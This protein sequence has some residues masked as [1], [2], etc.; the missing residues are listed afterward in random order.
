MLPTSSGFA[1]ADQIALSPSRAGFPVVYVVA[2]AQP[3][4]GWSR[5]LPRR[6]RSAQAAPRSQ[7]GPI[8]VASRFPS[9][10]HHAIA[11]EKFRRAARRDSTARDRP[12]SA[13]A[14]PSDLTYPIACSLGPTDLKLYGAVAP[15]PFQVRG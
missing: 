12:A 1:R 8:A 9:P 13:D 11:N 3:L 15:A 14:L 10:A 7:A 5:T 2:R 6:A 4:D